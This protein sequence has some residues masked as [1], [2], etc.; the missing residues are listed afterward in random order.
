MATAPTFEETL[1]PSDAIGVLEELLPAQTQSY[2]LGLRLSLPVH[3]VDAICAAHAQ[4]RERLLHILIAFLNQ[5]EPRPTWRVI[6]EALRSPA[7]NLPLLAQSVEAVHFP[8]ST[9]T[10]TVL[11]ASD[12]AIGHYVQAQ[13]KRVDVP[14]TR[15]GIS[16]R[17]M[18]SETGLTTEKDLRPVSPVPNP[19]TSRYVQAK[20]RQLEKRFNGL[21]R[22]SRSCLEKRKVPV[23]QVADTLMDLPADDMEEHKQFLESH[24]SVLYQ[25]H[26]KAELFGALSFNMNYLSY[27]LLDYLVCEFKLEVQDEMECYKEDLQAFRQR[28][29]MTLFCQTQKKRYV[30]PPSKFQEFVAR[31][32]WPEDVTLD[33]VEQFRQEYT[34]HY[35]LRECA[36]MLAEIRPGSFVITWFIP[37]CIV[38][39]L[40]TKLPR[41]LFKEYAIT[42]LKIAGDS[43]CC[44]EGPNIT[45]SVSSEDGANTE[46]GAA[47]D[48][49]TRVEEELDEEVF[50]LTE[51]DFLFVESPSSD[52]FCPVTT[53]LLLEPHLTFCCGSHLSQEAAV[54]IQR[55]GKSCPMCKTLDW[56]TVLNKHFQRQVNALQM[57]C[58][59]QNKGCRWQGE[60]STLIP[61]V[62]SCPMRDMPITVNECYYVVS[63]WESLDDR[64]I[65]TNTNPFAGNTFLCCPLLKSLLL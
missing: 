56:N 8:D 40:K 2:L 18:P 24:L 45:V 34:C 11:P 38:E 12:P 1:T 53:D 19:M 14:P 64:Y 27:H 62:K 25:A 48:Q 17:I 3:V 33:V 60:L 30:E 6:I 43:V 42:E 59:H 36:M 46:A 63:Q 49:T 54:R 5:V 44:S 22:A 35:N 55:D 47:L 39:K 10:R 4:P 37:E 7:V 21:K 32:E 20:I 26:D 16:T 57:F 52:F 41:E 29:P 13:S 50:E 61:H 28:T 9:A 31:F 23:K 58:C 51:D 65:V 15:S